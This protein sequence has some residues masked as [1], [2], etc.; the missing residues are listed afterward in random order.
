MSSNRHKLFK[1]SITNDDLIRSRMDTTLTLRKRKLEEYIENKR[2]YIKAE[3]QIE[4]D[5]HVPSAEDNHE[6][7]T[8][9]ISLDECISLLSSA[10]YQDVYNG[11][12]NIRIILTQKQPPVQDLYDKGGVRKI[13]TYLNEETSEDLLHEILWCIINIIYI[14][15]NITK[16]L[17]SNGLVDKLVKLMIVHKSPKIVDLFI[18]TISNIVA[19]PTT[20]RIDIYNKGILDYLANAFTNSQY[21]KSKT[22]CLWSIANLIQGIE[23]YIAT[24]NCARSLVEESCENILN[25]DKENTRD[26]RILK[27]SLL[28]IFSMTQ[29]N[30]SL[31]SI[32]VDKDM[33]PM[34]KEIIES[35]L[36][37][38]VYCENI[39]YHTLKIFGNF[40]SADEK[41]TNVIVHAGIQNI[42]K[43]ILIEKEGEFNTIKEALW[44]LS[45]ITV[46]SIPTVDNVLTDSK[47][48]KIL[49][50]FAGKSKEIALRKEAM[51]CLC[52][53]TSTMNK[54]FLKNLIIKYKLLEIVNENIFKG[55]MDTTLLCLNII[56]T[57]LVI[58][59]D[60]LQRVDTFDLKE[61]LENFYFYNRNEE[62]YN[63][64]QV[65]LNKF[66]HDA[67]VT[68]FWDTS[69]Q[70]MDI[71]DNSCFIYDSDTM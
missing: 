9:T 1:H 23:K 11:A 36:S 42:I 55:N 41:Y 59:S 21:K 33:I 40:S 32:L 29:Y 15:S 18:W 13:L 19:D 71:E 53:L 2:L 30:E 52:N 35:S 6:I 65:L 47:L 10:D 31:L 16:Y 63:K 22:N 56:E 60:I 50:T 3:N 67:I 69:F 51:W 62:I 68:D 64:S 28:I 8:K 54:K 24:T 27:Y 7:T 5:M 46:E 38:N 39:F 4:I 12:S 66:F 37:T 34:L 17:I 14:S 26:N 44:I 58:G 20:N 57:I 49:C 61:K 70:N 48:V 43:N 45:N 25:K